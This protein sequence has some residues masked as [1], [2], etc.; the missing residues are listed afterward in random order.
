MEIILPLD[1]KTTLCSVI[2]PH[3]ALSIIRGSVQDPKSKRMIDDIDVTKISTSYDVGH[4]AQVG[5]LSLEEDQSALKKVEGHDYSRLQMALT[6]IASLTD[7]EHTEAL[8]DLV[9]DPRPLI[10]LTQVP[11]KGHN[12]QCDGYAFIVIGNNFPWSDEDINRKHALAV[13]ILV[14][15]DPLTPL[16]GSMYRPIVYRTP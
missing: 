4:V 12:P 7:A 3:Y 1:I 5:F 9:R 2:N 6:Y 14:T 10:C 15:K 11:I 8:F 16:K 13:R